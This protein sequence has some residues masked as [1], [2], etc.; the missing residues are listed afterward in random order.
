MINSL[1]Q[2]PMRGGSDLLWDDILGLLHA[3]DEEAKALDAKAP[4]RQRLVPEFLLHW[5]HLVSPF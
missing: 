2:D 5:A 1:W 4:L 3:D